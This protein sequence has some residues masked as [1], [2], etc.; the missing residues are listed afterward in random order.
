M[1][2]PTVYPKQYQ[3][4]LSV[5]PPIGLC[6]SSGCVRQSEPR[7]GGDQWSIDIRCTAKYLSST[8]VALFLAVNLP[9]CR[10]TPNHDGVTFPTQFAYRGLK[11]YLKRPILLDPLAMDGRPPYCNLNTLYSSARGRDRKG[12][13]SG[14]AAQEPVANYHRPQWQPAQASTNLLRYTTCRC[15]GSR[16]WT[17]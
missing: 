17:E 3:Q 14:R 6:L 5:E 1:S 9:S 10:H 13:D 11:V 8:Q 7:Q 2:N 15:Q 16:H 4:A 12:K